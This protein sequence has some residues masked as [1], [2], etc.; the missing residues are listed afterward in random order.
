ME[1]GV[2]GL[3]NMG[4]AIAAQMINAGHDVTVYNRTEDKA[5]SLIAMGATE[6]EP[7]TDRSGGKETFVTASAIDPFG[8]VVGVMF[9]QHYLEIFDQ[10]N[11]QSLI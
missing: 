8:N 5:E 7:V 6:Y 9:N 2:I 10:K 3:G 4:A 11:A 1:V